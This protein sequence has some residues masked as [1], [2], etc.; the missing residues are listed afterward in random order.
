MQTLGI[1][2]SDPTSENRIKSLLW[3]SI[4]NATDMDYLGTQGYWVCAV[5]AALSLA[6]NVMQGH[7]VVGV[8]V[9]LFFY[10]GGVGVRER[11]RFAAAIVLLMYFAELLVGVP[12]IGRIVILGL[13]LSN[14]RATWLAAGWQPDS[15]EA[16]LPPRLNDTLGDKFADRLPAILWPKVRIPYYIYSVGF[17]ALVVV[18][19]IAVV[20]HRNDP[21][22]ASSY[23][24]RNDLFSLSGGP[25]NPYRGFRDQAL[26][27]ERE[28]LGLPIPRTPTQPWGVV[29]DWGMTDGTAT[30]VAFSDD[31]ANVYLSTG[32]VVGG[33]AHQGPVLKAVDS[34]MAVA[35]ASQPQFHATTTYPLPPAGQ[36]NFYLLTDSG[37][38]SATASQHDLSTHRH[39]LS[40]LADAGQNIINEYDKLHSI[41]TH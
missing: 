26:S 33:G 24:S 13:L 31:T 4:R 36:V 23:S 37:I 17:L 39:P 34:L 28:D 40:Q 30:V 2:T 8:F 41:P 5:V 16:I 38:F 35:A 6:V 20:R 15:A 9:F 18:G 32:V 10:L 3:P 29:M 21:H 19:L 11:S 14:V 7:S 1:S 12:S 22:T 25:P 27:S